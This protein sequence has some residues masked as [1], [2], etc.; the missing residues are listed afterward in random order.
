[1][2][3]RTPAIKASHILRTAEYN[4]TYLLGEVLKIPAATNVGKVQKITKRPSNPNPLDA[5]K[6]KYL[7]WFTVV[8][9]L[10]SKKLAKNPIIPPKRN[11]LIPYPV[12]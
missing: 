4:I 8:S 12:S 5:Y 6:L 11:I 7:A 2:H 9:F 1:M 3:P 10:P